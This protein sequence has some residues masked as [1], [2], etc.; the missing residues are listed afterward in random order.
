MK[1]LS[2]LLLIYANAYKH[3]SSASND[4]VN[5]DYGELAMLANL[6]NMI[7]TDPYSD[8]TQKNASHHEKHIEMYHDYIINFL[9][10]EDD[11]N[12]NIYICKCMKEHIYKCISEVEKKIE[13][14]ENEDEQCEKLYKQ[15][16]KLTSFKYD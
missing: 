4:N 5:N 9:N 13:E 7:A 15:Y 1:N 2:E 8:I 3:Y 14:Y 6:A 10:K 16:Q 12:D 11:D